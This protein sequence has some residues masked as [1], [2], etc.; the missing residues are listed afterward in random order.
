MEWLGKK[1]PP[2][3]VAMPALDWM[4]TQTAL[5]LRHLELPRGSEVAVADNSTALVV[6]R[7]ALVDH[8][9]ARPKLAWLLLL[10]ADM[11]FPPHTLRR[12]LGWN[13][14]VVSGLYSYKGVAPH[15]YEPVVEWDGDG[16]DRAIGDMG[17]L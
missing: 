13:V 7:N 6:K 10:D 1:Q 15:G 3:L 9:L 11:V 12:L 14:D 5:A 8:F 17:G 2:G 16:A 4:W